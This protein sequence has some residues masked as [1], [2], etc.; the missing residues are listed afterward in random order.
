VGNIQDICTQIQVQ[1]REELES[2]WWR[3]DKERESGEDSSMDISHSEEFSWLLL[4]FRA[5]YWI[6]GS[7]DISSK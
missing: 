6:A 7:L 1:Q 5:P 2:P 3:P 4:I